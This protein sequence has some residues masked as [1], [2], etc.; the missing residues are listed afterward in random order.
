M[1]PDGWRRMV[2]IEAGAIRT[3]VV[4]PAGGSWRASQTLVEL[5]SA[6]G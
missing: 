5:G 3:P 6:A 1:A 2:C 4:V